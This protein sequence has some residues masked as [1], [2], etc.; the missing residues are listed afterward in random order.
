[1]PIDIIDD[2]APISH[3]IADGWFEFAAKILPALG[4]SAQAQAQVAFHFGA[5]HVLQILKEVVAHESPEAAALGLS[6]LDAELDEFLK[7]HT[8]AIQ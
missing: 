7:A 1:M 5:L 8:S 2:D 6:M 4:G 3:A